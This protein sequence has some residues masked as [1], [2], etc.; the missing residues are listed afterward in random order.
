MHTKASNAPAC[1]H[2]KVANFSSAGRR[3]GCAFTALDG[4]RP[5]VCVAAG[6]ARPGF[7]HHLPFLA[8][9]LFAYFFIVVVACA[10]STEYEYSIPDTPVIPIC[11]GGWATLAG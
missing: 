6:L 5:R 11:D 4:R 9:W 7:S 3:L 2:S 8:G 1:A 10:S